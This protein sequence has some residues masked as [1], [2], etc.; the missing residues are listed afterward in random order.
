M[1]F[2]YTD[3]AKENKRSCLTFFKTMRSSAYYTGCA[4]YKILPK[5]WKNGILKNCEDN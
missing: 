1:L 5:N 2:L 4:Y 3:A